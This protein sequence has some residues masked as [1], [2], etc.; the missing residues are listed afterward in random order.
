MY[1]NGEG[2]PQDFKQ[3]IQWYT[4]AAEQGDVDAQYNLALMYKNGEGV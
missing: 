2:V 1:K 4:K 3:A